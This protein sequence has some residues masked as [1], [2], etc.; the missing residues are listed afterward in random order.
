VIE[1]GLMEKVVSAHSALRGATAQGEEMLQPDEVAAMVRLHG[2]GWGAKRLAREFGC[3]RNTVRRYLRQGGPTPFR[4]PARRSALDGLDDWLRERFFRHGGNADVVRQE[5]AA[6]RGIVLSLRHVERRVAPLRRALEAEARATV[7]FETP[8]GRQLQI[9]FGERGVVIGAE[10]VRVHL[11]VATLGYSR[12]IHVRASLR[13]RQ[14]DW[15]EGIESAFLHF[16]GVP[17]E[18]LLDNARALVEHHDAATREVR[19][20]AKL[21][22]FARHWGFRPRACAPYRARSKG[23]DER[24]VGYVKKNAIAGRRF[25]S[26]PEFEAHLAAWCREVADRRVHGT[27]GEAPIARFE[28]EAPALGSL[29]GRAAFGPLRDLVRRVQADCAVDVDTTSYSVPWR[30]IGET[31]QATICAGGVVIRHAGEVVADHA[32]CPGRRQRITERA[33]LAGVVGADGPVRRISPAPPPPPP[34]LLRPL[35]DYELAAG[36]GW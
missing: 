13:E 14:A 35:A 5:L 27:T 10:R 6:E 17:A 33:H 34:S 7:R 2:L 25:G 24:G 11:F 16:G 20:N 9:D 12:R 23:K 18:V 36:G 8:P 15:F 3:A 22:A 26:W 31:V 4:R 19:F 28:R 1:E 29:G 21:H 32:V 30:L